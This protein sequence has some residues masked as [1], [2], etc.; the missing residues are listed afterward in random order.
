MKTVKNKKEHQMK[1]KTD[2]F[3]GNQNQQC[4]TI[5]K[6]QNH[7]LKGTTVIKSAFIGFL[8]WFYKII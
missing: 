2:Y 1:I 8:L 5:R 3:A 4:N 7:K 6:Q